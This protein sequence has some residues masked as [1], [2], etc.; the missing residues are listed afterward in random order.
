VVSNASS[1][2]REEHY[3]T[4][5]QSDRFSTLL[6]KCRIFVVNFPGPG[7]SWNLLVVQI[8]RHAWRRILLT[9]TK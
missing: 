4:L 6:G 2:H 8:S 5:Y 7:E 1:W 9:E 3:K